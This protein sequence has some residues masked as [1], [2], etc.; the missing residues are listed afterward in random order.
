[1]DLFISILWNI[2]SYYTGGIMIFFLVG[3]GIF[4]TIGTRAIQFRK[5]GYALNELFS[6]KSTK[7]GDI[8]PF[9]ALTTS[10]AA[11]LGI[12]NIAGVAIAISS[13]G[14]GAVFWMWITAV[15][16]GA[17]KYGESLLA[18]RYRITN[19][20]G[21]K[22]GGPMY[23]IKLGMSERFGGDW[24]WLGYLFAI[25][26]VIASFGIGNMIQAN[27]VAHSIE[28]ST[29]IPPVITGSFITSATALVIFGG[30]KSIGK[31]IEKIVP[32]MIITYLAGALIILTKNADLIP[33]AFGLILTNAFS[34]KAVGGGLIGTVIR[35]GVARGVMSNE[36]G[37]GSSSIAHAASQS[38]DPVSQGI[39]GSL[40]SFVDTLIVCTM[41]A[42]VIMV[43]G[44]VS[45]DPG[46]GLMHIQGNLTG[47]ALTTAA[48][49]NELP[50]MGGLI[51]SFSLITFGFST[52]LGWYYYGSKCLEYIAGL[53]AIN[54]YKAVWV[55]LV[56]FGA[57]YKV[58]FVWNISDV[59]NSLMAIPNLIALIALSPLIFKMTAEHDSKDDNALSEKD[60][61]SELIKFPTTSI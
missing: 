8:S 47:A 1:M 56:F 45:I 33:N 4:L 3:T 15:F 61:K 17:L 16:G 28:V 2:D 9:Q 46:S 26:G 32:V 42:L 23:Y 57:V 48:F 6:K 29:S 40:G 60:Y 58:G 34:A 55:G 27:S 53:N 36:A 37:L 13:G 7:N 5:I 25:F 11:T 43:S 22:S 19:E 49:S 21:E 18:V 50:L 30:I 52:I 12:G 20:H 10:L 35:Y 59:F 51:V 24:T 38:D 54:L 31:V 14:P 44:L 39:I 41:T